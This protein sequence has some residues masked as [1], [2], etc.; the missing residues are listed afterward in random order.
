[1]YEEGVKAYLFLISIGSEYSSEK[2]Q[3]KTYPAPYPH[4][5]EDTGF[6]MVM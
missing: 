6:L 3:T 2:Q 1:M 5:S 4:L